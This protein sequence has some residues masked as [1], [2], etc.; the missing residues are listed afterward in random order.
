MAVQRGMEIDKR[1]EMSARFLEK[2]ERACVFLF[3]SGEVRGVV[4]VKILYVFPVG[5]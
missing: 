2:S 3:D 1:N 4:H 5:Y